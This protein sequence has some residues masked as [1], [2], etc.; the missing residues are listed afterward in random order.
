MR[1]KAFSLVE[2]LVVLSVVALMAA[3]SFPAFRKASA[4]ARR[5]QCQSN[6]R[7]IGIALMAYSSDNG[8]NLPPVSTAW[9]PP[10]QNATWA[11]AIWSYS[12]YAATAFQSP[13]NDLRLYGT[14][15]PRNVFRCPDNTPAV[16]PYKSGNSV[17]SWR[18]SYGLNM[19]PVGVLSQANLTRP[20]PLAVVTARS[21]TAMVM[22]SSFCLGNTDGYL[23]LYGL[24][25]HQN[26]SNV[27]YYDGH[28]EWLAANQIPTSTIDV[29][30]RGN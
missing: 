22:E 4:L 19:T 21:V 28:V 27:L 9:P 8:G 26:G 5:T 1:T 12:G 11:Y 30:W 16:P 6:L 25:P 13:N 2:M 17:N 20:I 3:L 24:L 14:A 18:M 15:D 10:S 29:F 23:S 7:Q